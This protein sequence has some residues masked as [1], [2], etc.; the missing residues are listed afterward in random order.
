MEGEVPENTREGEGRKVLQRNCEKKN[1]TERLQKCNERRK[2][3]Q[4][5][6][7]KR[8]WKMKNLS[9]RLQKKKKEKKKKEAQTKS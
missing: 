5:K 4:I 8:V 9:V 6:Q 3:S 1:K 7:D 2:K